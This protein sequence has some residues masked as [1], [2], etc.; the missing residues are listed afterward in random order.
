MEANFTEFLLR[1]TTL[2]EVQAYVLLRQ[3]HS[4]Q[5][6]R[7]SCWNMKVNSSTSLWSSLSVC[8]E[9][10]FSMSSRPVGPVREPRCM[11][12]IFWTLRSLMNLAPHMTM[13][14]MKE[15]IMPMLRGTGA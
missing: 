5:K 8:W 11:M 9:V 7:E 10:A 14:I 4:V 15:H 1:N 2:E 6:I 13:A 12:P 3:S